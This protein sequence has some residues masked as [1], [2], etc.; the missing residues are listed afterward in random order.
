MNETLK[1]EI[2]AVGQE[3]EIKLTELSLLKDQFL[4]FSKR[5]NIQ[6]LKKDEDIIALGNRIEVL[7][8]KLLS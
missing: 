3:V 8:E 6:E 1:Q 5:P 7:M 4:E 2:L